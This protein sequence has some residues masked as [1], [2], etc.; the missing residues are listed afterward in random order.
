MKLRLSPNSNLV[1]LCAACLMTAPEAAPAALVNL[2]TFNG[3]ANDSVGGQN[4]TVVDPGAATASYGVSGGQGYLDL[5]ANSGQGSNGITEDA[6][7]NLPN[8]IISAAS[9]SGTSGA[10]SVSVWVTVSTNRNWA[11]IYSFGTSNGG[12]DTS[13]GGSASPY[14][15]LIPQNG[16]TGTLRASTHA[17]GGDEPTVTAGAVLSA[18]VQHNLVTTYDQTA[19]IS[20][21]LDNT[22]VG[23]AA[24]ASGLT[25]NSLPDVNN[26]LGRSPWPDSVFD[27]LY[28]QV[29]IYNTALTAGEVNTQFLAGPTPVPETSTGVLAILGLAGLGRRRR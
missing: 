25:L 6:Y 2:Y 27:G 24:V 20:L 15:T 21:Y 28:N 12:E 17:A 1:A 9:N 11:E 7:V 10:F 19:G 29:A 18:G 23:T 3:N 8:G 22:L 16:A 26:W 14:V 4:G 13:G 5:S